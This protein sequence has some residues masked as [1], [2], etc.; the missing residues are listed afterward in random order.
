MTMRKDCAADKNVMVPAM[1]MWFVVQRGKEV[2]SEKLCGAVLV[3]FCY[4]R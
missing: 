2:N 1:K 3:Q 4:C